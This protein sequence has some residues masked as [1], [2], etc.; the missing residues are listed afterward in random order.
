MYKWQTVSWRCK[1]QSKWNHW[2]RL[3]QKAAASQ[4]SLIENNKIKNYNMKYKIRIFFMEASEALFINTSSWGNIMVCLEHTCSSLVKFQWRFQYEHLIEKLSRSLFIL[5]YQMKNKINTKMKKATT[6]E[7][8]NQKHKWGVCLLHEG[9][10]NMIWFKDVLQ[11][12]LG[13]SR[14]SQQK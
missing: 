9:C 4:K 5:F 8:N 7:N 11:S 3:L 2:Q 13:P 6:I 1:P 12:N 10:T 14:L